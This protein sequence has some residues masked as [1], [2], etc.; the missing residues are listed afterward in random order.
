MLQYPSITFGI[1]FSSLLIWSKSFYLLHT[2]NY[3]SPHHQ[4]DEKNKRSPKSVHS[5]PQNIRFLAYFSL[6]TCSW[7]SQLC[8]G[9]KLY[10]CGVMWM[11]TRPRREIRE[12][13]FL[14]VRWITC[15]LAQTASPPYSPHLRETDSKVDSMSSSLLQSGRARVWSPLTD[16]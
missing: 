10:V 3:F 14:S 6:Q 11:Y 12:I 1:R 8:F 4:W 13:P 9:K 2:G 15:H 16:F 7:D 5:C